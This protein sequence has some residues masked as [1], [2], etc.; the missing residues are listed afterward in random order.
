MPSASYIMAVTSQKGGSGR[1]T[2]SLALALAF[3]R[4][5]YSA[6][7]VDADRAGA[8]STIFR[9]GL[10]S[11][12]ENLS[13]RRQLDWSDADF[14]SDIA[15]VDAP[16]LTD[17]EA[18][19]VLGKAGGILLTGLADPLSTRTIPSA[20]R[21]LETIAETNREFELIG[22][23]LNA[24]DA[25]DSLQC[26]IRDMLLETHPDLILPDS[27]P[28]DEALRDWPSTPG[29]LESGPGFAT[30]RRTVSLLIPWIG[31]ALTRGG[32]RPAAPPPDRPEPSQPGSWD[33]LQFTRSQ[34]AAPKFNDKIVMVEPRSLLRR[35]PLAIQL[36]KG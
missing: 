25:D 3:A 17:P 15:I 13:F 35:R 14:A 22:L 11:T 10:P 24:V 4:A 33:P 28:F 9:D 26:Q 16:A 1:T 18:A 30:Y 36:L 19:G 27:I 32:V 34:P 29:A 12:W 8:L 31:P 20:I 6:T 5:G 21:A 23:M 7:L 2:T